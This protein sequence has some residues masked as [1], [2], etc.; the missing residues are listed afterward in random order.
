[1][2][3]DIHDVIACSTLVLVSQDA[4]FGDPLETSLD[5]IA[6]FSKVLGLLRHVD[7]DVWTGGLWAEAPDLFGI[8]RVPVELAI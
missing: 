6:N 3:H 2:R 8:V 4:F 7:Q 5:R 1:M